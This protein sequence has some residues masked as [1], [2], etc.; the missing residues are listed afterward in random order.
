MPF[1]ER[2]DSLG[3]VERHIQ[4]VLKLE[5]KDASR[6][7]KR[8][9]EVRQELRDRLDR[10]PEDTFSA[11]RMRGVLVQVDGA[12]AAMSES[13][14]TGMKD[15]AGD[16]ALLGVEHQLLEI[17]A[18]QDE[19]EGAVIPI[20]LNAQ[21]VAEDTERFLI[22]RHQ[23]SLDAYSEDVRSN[24]VQSLT[25]ESLA[26][27]SLSTVVRKLG[28]FFQGEE[29]KLL[30]IARTELHN[31]YS[32]GKLNGMREVKNDY[33]PDLKKA[34]M[35]PMDARTGDDSKA[36]AAE[37][38]AVPLDKPF[39]QRWKGKTFTFMAPPNRPNDRAI[40][41]PYRKGWDE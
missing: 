7:L 19:F 33:I 11:Q 38:P 6:L 8:Y 34:L 30:R 31:V 25:N 14:K 35:H 1:F 17:R 22:N 32:V 9:R 2:V 13:L 16:A 27:S 21:L 40:L 41:V 10:F 29:W 20:N 39:V 26:Q 24:L 12:I 4:E 18:F 36:L 15:V 23:A 37:D 5:D 3:I 28:A